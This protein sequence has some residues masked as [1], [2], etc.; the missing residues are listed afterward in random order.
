MFRGVCSSSSLVVMLDEVLL[1]PK[2]STT[3]R[4][5]AE[6]GYRDERG[7][8]MI[9]DLEDIRNGLNVEI[10]IEPQRCNLN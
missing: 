9:K 7:Y 5:G 6:D 4:G 1:F 10:E 3:D 8:G 2:K